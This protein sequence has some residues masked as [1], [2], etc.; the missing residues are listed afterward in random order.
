MPLRADREG[1][2]E[3][4]GLREQMRDVRGVDRE[5]REVQGAEVQSSELRL[6]GWEVRQP[7]DRGV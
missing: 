5:L 7:D 4:Y 1:R 2:A 3:V 6:R